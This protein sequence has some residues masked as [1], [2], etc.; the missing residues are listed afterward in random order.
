[1]HDPKL[2]PR[3]RNTARQPLRRWLMT[4]FFLGT[5]VPATSAMA[6]DPPL[7]IDTCVTYSERDLDASTFEARLDSTCSGAVRCELSWAVRCEPGAPLRRD[8]K[9]FTVAAGGDGSARVSLKHCGERPWEITD[10][11]WSCV[12]KR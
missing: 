10:L 5:A 3:S 4:A 6:G 11:S 8:S 7:D 9:K 12:Q 2:A 1:M